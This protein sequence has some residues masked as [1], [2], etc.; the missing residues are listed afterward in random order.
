M[1]REAMAG[2]DASFIPAGTVS[3]WAVVELDNPLF[4]FLEPLK[5]IS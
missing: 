1:R 4:M 2:R 3:A 5:R